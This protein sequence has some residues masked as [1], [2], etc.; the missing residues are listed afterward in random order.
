MRQNDFQNVFEKF[1]FLKHE[2]SDLHY[3]INSLMLNPYEHLAHHL[4]QAFSGL[5]TETEVINEILC[6]NKTNEELKQIKRAYE[7]RTNFTLLSSGFYVISLQ[8][9]LPL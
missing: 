3:L 1:T 5:G 6:S 8:A 4:R 9:T 2:S 7:N